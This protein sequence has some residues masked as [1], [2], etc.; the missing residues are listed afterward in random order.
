MAEKGRTHTGAR[1]RL[2]INGVKVGYALNVTI[3]EE[4]E[5][6]PQ[7][8][9]DNIQVDEHIPVAYRCNASASVVRI[10]GETF[11]SQNL[12]P[13]AGTSPQEHLQN[14]LLTKDFVLTLEDT[15]GAGTTVVTMEQVK[16]TSQN[17]SVQ[18]RG[19]AGLD[20]SMVGIVVKDESE[21]P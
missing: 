18:A 21:V 3:N 13:K 2:S 19:I 11:K 8:L 20:V 16:I 12:F 9:L 10:V 17:L 1:A 4:L 15:K 6:Q 7:E 5:Y 14:I